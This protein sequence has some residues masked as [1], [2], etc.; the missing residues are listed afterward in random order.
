MFA[1]TVKIEEDIIPKDEGSIAYKI[2]A[3]K[4]GYT[5]NVDSTNS[6]FPINKGWNT[7]FYGPL[8]IPKK[9]DVV[10]LNQETFPEYQWIISEY[11]H[12]K[13]ENKNGKLKWTLILSQQLVTT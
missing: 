1:Y 10:Q 2:N 8:K 12:H 11:E 6:V 4:T 13:L 5:K 3:E 9:G 7:D